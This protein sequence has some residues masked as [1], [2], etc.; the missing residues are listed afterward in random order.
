MSFSKRLKKN[1]RIAENVI[2]VCAFAFI[3]YNLV[4]SYGMYIY[5]SVKGN[6]YFSAFIDPIIKHQ[7][8]ISIV[9][10][11]ILLNATLVLWEIFSFALSLLK[12]ERDPTALGYHQYKPIFKKVAQHYKSSFLALL[13]NQLLPKLI[14][15]HMFWI[16]LP[17]F[18]KLQLFTINLAWYSWLYGYLCW[19]FSSWLFHFTCHRVRLLWCIHSPHHAPTELNITVNW[20]HF[21]AE[22]YYSTLVRLLIL[23]VFGVNP[24]MFAAIIAID[25]AW[26][27]F[28]HVSERTLKDGRLGI[29]QH[30]IITPAHHRVHHAKNPLYLDTNFA[31]VLPVW[32]WVLGTLQPLREEVK[33]EYGISRELDVTNFSDLYFG[34]LLLLYRDVK[35]ASGIKNKI[36][37]ILKP[38]GWSPVSAANT[39]AVLRQEFLKIN[40]GLGIT[41]RERIFSS[42]KSPVDEGEGVVVTAEG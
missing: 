25:S 2:F 28:I 21:F 40:P 39:A 9:S 34:E 6:G 3:M 38:P 14:L 15:F 42:I 26:G 22:S 13:V 35:N 1:L 16:W 31:N 10:V 36:R 33:T 7:Y 17:H 18:Q 23:M 8:Y 4:T 41:S 37:Y 29:L 27:I 12:Q 19:E 11:I 24:A 20:I 30:I 32:D 5:R